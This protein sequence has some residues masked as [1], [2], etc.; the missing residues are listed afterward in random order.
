MNTATTPLPPYS[1]AQEF[2]DESGFGVWLERH[3][4]ESRVKHALYIAG[5]S[6]S[7][8][9]HVKAHRLTI[10]MGRSM[11]DLDFRPMRRIRADI[12]RA[13]QQ[14]GLPISSTMLTVYRAGSR[15]L[16]HVGILEPE[17]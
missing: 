4:F 1:S 6:R 8:L 10:A 12:R 9:E 17:A 2:I 14:E 11:N 3:T 13:F 7:K 15:L 5:F 16:A